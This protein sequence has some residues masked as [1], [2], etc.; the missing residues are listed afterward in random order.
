MIN[1]KKF[2]NTNSTNISV[3]TDERPSPKLA[4][5]DCGSTGNVKN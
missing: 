3:A 1:F 5:S 2:K 4:L